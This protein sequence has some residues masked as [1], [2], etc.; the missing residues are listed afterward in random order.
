MWHQIFL[1][2]R[3]FS[4]HQVA[5]IHR[6]LQT[7]TTDWL[8]CLLVRSSRLV[9]GVPQWASRRVSRHPRPGPWKGSWRRRGLMSR[10]ARR[11]SGG[12][13]HNLC[14]RWRSSGCPHSL[15]QRSSAGLPW[16]SCSGAQG[17]A[18]GEEE[19]GNRQEEE[20]EVE[21][22]EAS[23]GECAM[24]FWPWMKVWKRSGLEPWGV[25]CETIT[26]VEQM[27]SACR[28]SARTPRN[29]R[30]ERRHWCRAL[31]CLLV[32]A[33]FQFDLWCCSSSHSLRSHSCYTVAIVFMWIFR[34]HFSVLG[35]IVFFSFFVDNASLKSNDLSMVRIFQNY[36]EI[37]QFFL[38]QIMGNKMFSMFCSFPI[39]MAMSSSL[40]NDIILNWEKI[41]L[42]IEWRL[43]WLHFLSRDARRSNRRCLDSNTMG[44]LC[45]TFYG[46]SRTTQTALHWPCP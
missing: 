35:S 18:R 3:P 7:T 28:L 42:Y 39:A 43:G 31:V 30:C 4:L 5:L 6:T 11:R 25:K 41:Q 16:P 34:R 22:G 24:Y 8:T 15:L 38:Y 10:W 32:Y 19:D 45:I 14:E 1:I 20:V 17:T 21:S 44:I 46:L 12:W 9:L 26:T 36:W 37:H 2:D 23:Q 33:S 29:R 13:A 27:R 40:L